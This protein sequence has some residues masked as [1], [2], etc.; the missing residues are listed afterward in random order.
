MDE[1]YLGTKEISI[2]INC[3]PQSIYNLIHKGILKLGV[4]YVKP[5]KRKLLF[6]WS[7]IKE[8][9]EGSTN[10]VEVEDGDVDGQEVKR[11]IKRSVPNPKCKIN[12]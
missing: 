2:R 5:S 4:H 1:Q 6:K 8:W 7:A 11:D 12:I 10:N 3:A 9:L